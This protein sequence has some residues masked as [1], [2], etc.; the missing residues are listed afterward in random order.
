M[1][2]F[3]V[4]LVLLSVVFAALG[5]LGCFEAGEIG[6]RNGTGSPVRV[7]VLFGCSS[8][9]ESEDRLW[10]ILGPGESGEFFVF[11]GGSIG[12]PCLG[13][14]PGSGPGRLVEVKPGR[15]YE[16]ISEEALINVRDV[17]EHDQPWFYDPYGLD[18]GWSSW[19]L[20]FYVVP[21]ALGAPFGLYITARHFYRF[22]VL[23]QQ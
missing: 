21:I 11:S 20:W 12:D 2:V 4:R 9:R 1:S 14:L 10:R 22:Y 5:S 23:K 18:I 13:V 15:L 6:V 8:P 7:Q 3:R 19:L 16:V 17:G